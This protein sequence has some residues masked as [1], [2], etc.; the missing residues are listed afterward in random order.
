[1]RK[2]NNKLSLQGVK[3]SQKNLKRKQNKMIELEKHVDF[4]Y[5]ILQAH[6]MDL[7][8][9]SLGRTTKEEKLIIDKLVSRGR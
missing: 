9:L 2:A 7:T 6:A 8:K 3:R 1:M 4:L 5:K